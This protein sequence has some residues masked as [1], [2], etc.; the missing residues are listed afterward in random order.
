[1]NRASLREYSEVHQGAALPNV[2]GRRFFNALLSGCVFRRVT[3]A[4]FVRSVLHGSKLDASDIRDFLGV[5]MTLDCFTFEGLQLS[6]EAFDAIL[7]LL[8][9]TKGNDAARARVEACM[10]HHRLKLYRRLFPQTE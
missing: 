6:P 7:F 8:T 4:Q 5:T 9:M 3:D 1:M 10:D 2:E